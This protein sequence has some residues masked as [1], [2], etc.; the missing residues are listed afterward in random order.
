VSLLN[1]I[2]GLIEFSATFTREDQ[3]SPRAASVFSRL[4]LIAS[5]LTASGFFL[6]EA[7]VW[8]ALNS[9]FEHIAETF[10]GI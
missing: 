7:G 8:H 5:T 2:L 4:A 9:H 3:G 6:S 10:E 1:D